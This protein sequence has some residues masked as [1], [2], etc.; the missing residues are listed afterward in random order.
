M[1]EF[2]WNDPRH[3]A[4]SEPLKVRSSRLIEVDSLGHNKREERKYDKAAFSFF[5]ASSSSSSSSTTDNEHGE[6]VL[7][8]Y[9]VSS[10][11]DGTAFI[12]EFGSSGANSFV[13][14]SFSSDAVFIL[15]PAT[16]PPGESMGASFYSSLSPLLIDARIDRLTN[17]ALSTAI[18]QPPGP[19]T[20]SSTSSPARWPRG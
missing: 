19:Q 6:T 11:S 1:F 16:E 12:C 8:H 9:Q 5:L 18:T 17:S 14:Y 13:V 15:A 3:L 20:T 10:T 4:V 2:I 7:R